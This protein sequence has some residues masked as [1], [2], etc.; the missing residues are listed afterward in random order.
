MFVPQKQS[1][2]SKVSRFHHERKII[3]RKRIKLVKPSKP[4][5]LMKS[6]LVMLEK[7]LCDSHLDEKR[8]EENAAVTKITDDPNNSSGMSRSLVFVKLTLVLL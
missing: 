6:H 4:A 2:K 1:K 8:F 5:P 3:M 7:Q